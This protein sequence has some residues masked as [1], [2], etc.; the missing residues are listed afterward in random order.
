MG[1]GIKIPLATVQFYPLDV[2]EDNLIG[3]CT[4]CAMENVQFTS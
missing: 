1:Y 2:P 3:V 4:H